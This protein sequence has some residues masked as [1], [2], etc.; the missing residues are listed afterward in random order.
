MTKLHRCMQLITKSTAIR[1]VENG[2]LTDTVSAVV[3]QSKANN[4]V[5]AVGTDRVVTDALTATVVVGTLVHVCTA[6][7]H[8]HLYCHH[9]RLSAYRF[10]T[11]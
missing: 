5:A 1:Y 2:Q 6:Y 4:T 9:H 7:H 11:A 10:P 8:Q 3:G